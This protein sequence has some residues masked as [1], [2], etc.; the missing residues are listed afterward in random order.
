MSD[1]QVSWRAGSR[2]GAPRMARWVVGAIIALLLV[3]APLY[4]DQFWL[5]LGV[6]AAAVA[7]GAIGLNI[8]TGTAG[9]LSLAH[10]FFM[11]VGALTYVVLSSEAGEGTEGAMIGLGLPPIIGMVGGVLL[12]GFCGLAFSPLSGRL[13]GIY[14]G[15][16]SLALV[17]IGV[18][19][20]NTATPLSG[21]FNGRATPPFELFGLK[22]DYSADPT[23]VFGVPFQRLEWLWYLGVLALVLAWW[24]ARNLVAGRPGRAMKLISESEIAASVMGINVMKY[25]AKAFLLSSVYAGL[26]GVLYALAIGSIA[27]QSFGMD[28]SIQFF[29]MVVI[30]GLGSVGGSVAGAFFVVALPVVIQGLSASIPL[31]AAGTGMFNTGQISKFLYGLAIVLV[32][33]FKPTGLAGFAGDISRAVSRLFS[34]HSHQPIHKEELK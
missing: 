29:A 28:L 34:H 19:V 30:G 10:P 31:V 32:L 2:I 24:F 25:K 26:A 3:V 1:V 7:V 22:L 21:G 27:P 14:L 5:Q 33:L 16:A 9:Q 20:L 13:K 17:L 6:S 23:L 18:H 8:V 4:L 11:A 12:A 15:M